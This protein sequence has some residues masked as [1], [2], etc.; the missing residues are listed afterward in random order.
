MDNNYAPPQSDV[1]AN[2]SSGGV[3]NNVLAALGGTKPWVLFISVLILI[4]AVFT[5]I[6]VLGLFAAVS[7][8]PVIPGIFYLVIGIYIAMAVAQI[9][10][11][12]YLIKY[13]SGIGR[14]LISRQTDHLEE[15]LFAQKKFW[16]LAGIIGLI[17]IILMI[18]G[19]VMAA[20]GQIDPRMFR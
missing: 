9:F 16:K 13:S 5:V 6:A 12:I 11:G 17:S 8:A 20:S 3:S 15:S 4:G 19:I 1:S 10:L 7:R 2:N 14:V 18:I